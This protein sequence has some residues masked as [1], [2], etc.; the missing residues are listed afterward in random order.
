MKIIVVVDNDWGIGKD[1]QLL[2]NLKKDLKHFKETT[3]GCTVV[4][5]SR[6]LASLPGG[7]PLPNRKNIILNECQIDGLSCATSL[8]ELANIL[9]NEKNEVFIIGGASVYR[10]M[11]PYCSQAIITKVDDSRPADTYF[12]NLD[13]HPSWKC[14][15]QS[16]PIKD[17][18]H[19][20]R[21]CIY[22]N[23]NIKEFTGE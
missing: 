8:K 10:C 17:G 16:P 22:E 2:Y 3:E 7:K 1:N 6:T 15:S 14:I 20:I 19:T 23:M 4:M 5:G 13:K 9:K 12:E 11:L 21:F 18:E